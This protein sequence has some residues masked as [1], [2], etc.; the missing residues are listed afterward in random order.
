MH[1]ESLIFLHSFFI[2]KQV[3]FFPSHTTNFMAHQCPKKVFIKSCPGTTF[4]RVSGVLSR[5][6]DVL[7]PWRLTDVLSPHFEQRELTLQ[8]LKQSFHAFPFQIWVGWESHR[9]PHLS[10]SGAW[11][12]R[13]C[14]EPALQGTRGHRAGQKE[15]LSLPGDQ[16]WPSS[17][18]ILRQAGSWRTSPPA[19]PASHPEHPLPLHPCIP[20]SLRPCLPWELME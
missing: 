17:S 9:H 2:F 8:D 10:Q 14:K 1:C 6:S 7:A 15:Q 11:L 16:R 12:G 18:R 20:A 4:P 13:P 19:G 3:I 5:M